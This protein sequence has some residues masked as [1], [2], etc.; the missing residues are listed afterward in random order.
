VEEEKETRPVAILSSKRGK[1]GK[2]SKKKKKKRDSRIGLS[3]SNTILPETCK[4]K[5]L[6]K[7]GGEGEPERT[8]VS[9]NWSK[10]GGKTLKKKG[11]KE[12]ERTGMDI[13][14]AVSPEVQQGKKRG[15]RSGRMES[16]S[17]HTLPPA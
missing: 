5:V 16:V 8:D 1:K 13:I 17:I 6:E 9:F 2:S 14:P 15:G 12:R 4:E 3:Y 7:K 10:D 11:E